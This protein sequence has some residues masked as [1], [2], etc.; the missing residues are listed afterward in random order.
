MKKAIL[1]IVGVLVLL[2]VFGAAGFAY[3]QITDAPRHRTALRHHAWIGH[4]GPFRPGDDGCRR[5]TGQCMIIWS[6]RWLPGS[7]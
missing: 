4:D 2:A 3:A 7:G 6:K 1:V 5:V